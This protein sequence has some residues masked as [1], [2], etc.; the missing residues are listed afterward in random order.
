MA[1]QTILASATADVLMPT[2]FEQTGPCTVW[3]RG[4]PDG[5]TVVIVGADENDADS[6]VPL[7][8]DLMT[9]NEFVNRVGAC[10]VEC[11]GTY[12]LGALVSK[13]GALTDIT[14][15]TTQ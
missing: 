9:N 11:Q 13:A 5:A 15:V 7:H 2:L 3:V 4:V 10:A 8:K 1:T 6:A 12:Y 14:V